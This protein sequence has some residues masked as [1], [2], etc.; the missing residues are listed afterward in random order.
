MGDP[1]GVGPEIIV[2]ALNKLSVR[3]LASFLIIGNAY[4]LDKAIANS[5]KKF[6]YKQVDTPEFSKGITLYEPLKWNG[7]LTAPGKW[8]KESGRQ[9]LEYVKLATELCIA[10]KADAIV[11]CPICKAA[12]KAAGG[13]WPGHTELL[14]ELTG[15][16]DEVMML[17]G[18]G[19]RVALATIH[20]P[21]VKVSKLI[22]R[23]RI[24]HTA[25]IILKD[26]KNRFGI[27]TPRLAILGLNPHAGEEGTI[28]REEVEIIQPAVKDLQRAKN[29][30]TGPLPADTSFHRMLQGDFDAI[31]AMYHDQGLGPLKTLAFDSGVN[32]TLGLPI[33]RTSV[34]HGT[35]FD[36]AGKGFGKEDSLIQA[37]ITAVEMSANN[38]KN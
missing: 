1:L 38:S 2:K 5:G 29:A 23:E 4:Y 30:V 14:A 35:A 3:R 6:S 19:L 31:L 7:I 25:K 34:D 32:I 21:L 37:I 33:I 28:G 36:I 20:E 8:T 26:L 10:K 11:T 12:W 15:S 16:D 22:T 24:R 9:S 27:K 18:G 13:N 17:A